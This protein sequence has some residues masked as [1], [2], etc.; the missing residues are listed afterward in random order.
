MFAYT[1]RRILSAIPVIIGVFT[2]VFL[3]LHITPGDP[4]DLLIPAD[5]SGGAAEELAEQLRA[6]YGLDEPMH[7]QYFTYLGRAVRLDLGT[8]IRTGSPVFSSL[9]QRYPATLE[10]A[11]CSL[12]LA[13]IIGIPAGVLASLNLN[14]VR[15]SLCTTVSLMGVSIP[16]FWLGL[17]LMLLFSLRLGWL[18]PSGRAGGLWSLT[19]LKH[20]I[21]PAVTIGT[22]VTG[23]LARLTRS[24]MLDVL[25]EDYIR[26]A[27]AKGVK[28]QII[29]Y[30]HA[31]KNAMIP[32]VTVLGLQFGTLLA[33][34]VIAET[35]FAWPGI[36]R[37]MVIAIR[38]NDFPV[39]QG[40]VI[41]IA[42]T[43]VLVNLLVDLLYGVLDPRIT[44]D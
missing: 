6:R 44:Y 14:N 34:A 27:R 40:G 2:L 22:A 9:V 35:V 11:V 32:V 23:I 37:Y 8:S 29:N 3:S 4:I 10:L 28:E 18:P 12:L 30:R 43:F 15:D 21:M 17:L 20:M 13:I 36:G 33:G 5:V 26:T 41:F 38:G 39:V 25:S 19:A 31:M 42:V 7:V 24:A 1:V 16:N